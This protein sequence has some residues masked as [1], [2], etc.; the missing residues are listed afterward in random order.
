MFLFMYFISSFPEQL[1]SPEQFAELMCDDMDLNPLH[2]VPA[3]SSAIRQ[4]IESFPTDNPV[5]EGQTDQRLIIKVNTTLNLK[6]WSLKC[7][8]KRW[9]QGKMGLS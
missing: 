2:F 6:N 3:I 9:F 1:I 5:L 8:V 4:Q 7:Q